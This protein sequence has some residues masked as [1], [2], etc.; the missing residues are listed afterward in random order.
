MKEKR[1]ALAMLILS[2]IFVTITAFLLCF[3]LV[4]TGS[5]ISLIYSKG[6]SGWDALGGV[7]I[8]VYVILLSIGVSVSA[9][10]A[11]P[12]N[13]V[14]MLKMNVKTWYT[15]AILIFIIVAV[16]LAIFLAFSLPL[17]GS[18]WPN[19]SSSSSTPSSSSTI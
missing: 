15:K 6:A 1:G 5:S 14:L 3:D 7:I 8:Y 4:W 11:L 19:S 9:L 18:L 17:A 12:F 2:L 16:V 10:L 13:L